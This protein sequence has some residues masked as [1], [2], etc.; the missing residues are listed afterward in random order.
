MKMKRKRKDGGGGAKIVTKNV[1][2][3]INFISPSAR[4]KK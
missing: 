1:S 3:I 2:T 4:R